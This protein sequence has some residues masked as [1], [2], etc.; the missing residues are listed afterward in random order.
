MGQRLDFQKILEELLGSR[1]VYWQPPENISM[2]YP[3][4]VYDHDYSEVDHANDKAYRITKR[5]EVTSISRKSDDPTP[6]KLALLPMSRFI[7][8]F[9]AN[10]LNHYVYA[11][12]Y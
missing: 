8:S 1:S 2:V 4:I 10:G 5:Y 11:I 9:K 12:Y 7:R 3:A 6:D